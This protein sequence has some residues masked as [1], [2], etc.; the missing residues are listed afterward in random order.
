M[1]H[2]KP[3]EWVAYVDGEAAPE[4]S[5]RLAQHLELCPQ[6][7]AEIRGW[8]RTIARLERLPSPEMQ[9][10]WQRQRLPLFKYGLAAALVLSLGVGLGTLFRPGESQLKAAI[11]AEVRAELSREF[12]AERAAS[13]PQA[14]AFDQVLKAVETEA[15]QERRELWACL[16]Q[17]QEQNTRAFVLL[18][19]DLETAVWQADSDLEQNRERLTQL[20]TTLYAKNNKD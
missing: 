1:I 13:M 10:S 18:R 9:R 19:Q 6:C 8:Q 3:E 15:A 5:T 7:A 4:L 14:Q 20:A 2:P 17:F 11:V 12:K 16:Y